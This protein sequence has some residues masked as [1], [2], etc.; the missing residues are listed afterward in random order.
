MADYIITML[1][2]IKIIIIK[3]IIIM[4]E[5]TATIESPILSMLYI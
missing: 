1:I 4:L 2:I 3:I 5:F